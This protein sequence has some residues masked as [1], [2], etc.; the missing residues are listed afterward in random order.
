MPPREAAVAVRTHGYALAMANESSRLDRSLPHP[1][2]FRL[3]SS[4]RFAGRYLSADFRPW[5][6]FVILGTQRGGTTSLYRWLSGH[7]DVAPALK[8]EVHYFDGHYAKGPRWYRA[9]FPLG[10]PHRISGESCPFL[11]Y[12]PLAPGRVARDLPASSRFIVLLREPAERAVSQYWHWRQQGRWETESLERAIDLEPERL[13]PQAERF[14]RGERSVEH[15]AFSYVARGEYAGQLKRWFDAV[16][17]ERILVLES[18][19]LYTDPAASEQVLDWLG[20][21]NHGEPF[22]AFNAAHRSEEASP[23]LME[24]LRSHFKPHNEA[25]FELLGYELWTGTRRPPG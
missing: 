14:G 22:V 12:H 1:I 6:R 10:R 9:H 23:E 8:K 25:L 18:E 21:S 17:R 5:P 19:R 7:P 16:G 24:R 13:R 20:L 3:R 11:L 2:E 4:A 15:I